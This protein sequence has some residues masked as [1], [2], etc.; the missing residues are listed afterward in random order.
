MS[1]ESGK[2][3]YCIF[4]GTEPQKFNVAP[5]GNNNSEVHTINYEDLLAVVS[6]TDQFIFDPTRENAMAHEKVIS[7]V[8]KEHTVVPMS[9]GNVFKSEGDIVVLLESIYDE[10]KGV[11]KDVAGKIE[12]G[13][14]IFWDFDEIIREIKAE[15]QQL[16]N[17]EIDSYQSQIRAGEQVSQLVTEKKEYYLTKI[18]EPLNELAIVSKRNKTV[19]DKMILNAAFLIHREVEEDF[20]IKVNELYEKFEDQ[21]KFKYTGPWPPYNFVNIKLEIRDE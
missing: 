21:L 6:N 16:S 4:Q 1:T 5:I 3:L 13:L 19:G 12:L 18:M 14:K 11:L 20:D 2:Y 7:E 8:M 9:F 15:N 10:I 17:M